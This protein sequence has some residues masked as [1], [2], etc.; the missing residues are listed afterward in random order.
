MTRRRRVMMQTE[1][2]LRDK[3][4]QF[5]MVDIDQEIWPEG[6][7]RSDQHRRGERTLLK[8]NPGSLFSLGVG[9]P[10][11]INQPYRVLDIK[12]ADEDAAPITITYA[13]FAQTGLV[14]SLFLDAQLIIN[15]GVKNFQQ[16]VIVDVPPGGG[17]L[18]VH[19]SSVQADVLIKGGLAADRFIGRVAACSGMRPGHGFVPTRTLF[20]GDIAA[21]A[22]AFS[23]DIPAM[24]DSMLLMFENPIATVPTLE[25]ELVGGGGTVVSR[26]RYDGA[27]SGVNHW[28]GKLS[29]IVPKQLVN[30]FNVANVGAVAASKVFAV[31]GLAL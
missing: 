8:P 23:F 14:P 1:D 4:G 13:G 2:H 17:T 19:G 25:V 16:T 11:P 22:T 3:L 24:A 31:F 9:T 28:V 5:D 29:T 12:R 30:V 27:L 6:M 7:D 21:G 10:F 26:L 20:I 15:Y 18:T